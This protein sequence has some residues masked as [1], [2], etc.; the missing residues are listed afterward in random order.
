MAL[1]GVRVLDLLTRVPA[2]CAPGD[3]VCA[4]AAVG[5]TQ[6]LT[7]RC[8]RSELKGPV[9]LLL[10]RSWVLSALATLAVEAAG[11]CVLIVA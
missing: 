8:S 9:S 10:P 4:S 5:L 1:A 6:P 11:V 7:A 2:P 3:A